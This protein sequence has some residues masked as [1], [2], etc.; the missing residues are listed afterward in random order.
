MS[1]VD[2]Q[3]GLQYQ[4]CISFVAQALHTNGKRLVTL[5]TSLA[6]VAPMAYPDFLYK[7]W[8]LNSGLYIGMVGTLPT[9]FSF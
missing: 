8:G 3:S 6:T 1:F 5:L 4:T 7:Y 9:E 2:A